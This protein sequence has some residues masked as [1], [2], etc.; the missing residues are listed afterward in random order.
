MTKFD[1]VKNGCEF[2]L[3]V[4]GVSTGVGFSVYSDNTLCYAP[5]F[6][7]TLCNVA[8]LDGLGADA[9]STIEKWCGYENIPYEPTLTHLLLNKAISDAINCG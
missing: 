2:A 8:F 7:H 9:E 1:F 3:T 6:S 4:D 5:E